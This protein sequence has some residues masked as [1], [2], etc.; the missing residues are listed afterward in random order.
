MEKMGKI[1]GF[2]EKYGYIKIFLRQLTE[3]KE[4]CHNY[5]LFVLKFYQFYKIRGNLGIFERVRESSFYGEFKK[6]LQLLFDFFWKTNESSY[7]LIKEEN[8]KRNG[9]IWEFLK[10]TEISK[11]F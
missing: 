11:Y 1:G 5:C 10:N 6:N 9:E 3:K 4:N 8:I 7:F 2:L